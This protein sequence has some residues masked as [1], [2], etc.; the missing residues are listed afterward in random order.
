MADVAVPPLY[1][2]SLCAGGGGLDL[3]VELAYPGY[4]AVVYVEREA[5]A[6]AVLATR[7][8]EGALA[9]A[10]IWDD[11]TTFDG[12]PWRGVVDCVVAGFPCQPFSVAGKQLGLAD[13]RWL[14]PDIARL[15]REIKPPLVFLEN[16]PPVVRH[17]L[18]AIQSDLADLGYDSEWML[19]RASDV[20]ASHRRERF[21][22]LAH[23]PER[24]QR[25]LRE[26]SGGAGLVD[27]DDAGVADPLSPALHASSASGADG[28]G[29]TVAASASR[30]VGH[31]DESGLEGYGERC[32][33]G[34]QKSDELA[35]PASSIQDVPIFP[36]G[37]S[38]LDAWRTILAERPDLAPAVE[39]SV[40]GV[41]DGLASRVDR[42]RA[43]GNGVVALQAA[44]AFTVLSRRLR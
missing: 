7:M 31:A 13:E 20:G 32:R 19:L 24:G 29:R 27:R 42:L 22:L 33:A 17:G 30:T 26:S 34:R 11:L 18:G 35:A 39:S 40:R 6:A 12:R 9:D 23:G 3:G 2:L 8:A 28:T 10:P 25:M 38:D 44:V 41:A 21:F 15:L 43:C 14:W 5:Y 1:G 37:P 16:V 4:R 36:P